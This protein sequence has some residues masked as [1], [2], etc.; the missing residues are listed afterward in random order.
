[1]FYGQLTGNNS[2]TITVPFFDNLQKI[3]SFQIGHGS[4]SQVVNHK[5]MGLG[6]L[7]YR[8]SVATVT[9]ASAIW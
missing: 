2:R 8:F 3:S 7:R 9:L 5:H 4:K 6:Q 1:M